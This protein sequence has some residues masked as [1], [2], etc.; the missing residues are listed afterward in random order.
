MDLLTITQQT[1][2]RAA[3]DRIIPPDQFPGGWEVGVGDYF[4]RQFTGDLAAFVGRYTVGL[5]ALD[6]LA[7]QGDT[8]PFAALPTA[9]Q[10]QLLA[11]IEADVYGGELAQFFALLVTHAMEGYYGNP[12]NGGNRDAVAWQMIGFEVRG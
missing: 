7:R 10:D 4:A 8:I 5:D 11:Q 1:T 2:L 3:I 12:E 9:A 6:A